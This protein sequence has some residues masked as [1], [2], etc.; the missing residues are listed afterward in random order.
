MMDMI[1]FIWTDLQL[2]QYHQHSVSVYNNATFPT[3]YLIEIPKRY[4]EIYSVQLIQYQHSVSVYNNATFPFPT[5][6]LIENIER[7]YE[8]HSVPLP[9]CTVAKAVKAMC[10]C[11]CRILDAIRIVIPNLILI[12]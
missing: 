4:D 10:K 9:I 5:A 12:T 1:I 8:I 6:D 2:I 11:C 3:A 7:Y